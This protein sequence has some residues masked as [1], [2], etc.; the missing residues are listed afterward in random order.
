M[1]VIYNN[2]MQHSEKQS[3]S[4]KSARIQLRLETGHRVLGT[5]YSWD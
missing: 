3:G 4:S 5:N 1:Q 2:L